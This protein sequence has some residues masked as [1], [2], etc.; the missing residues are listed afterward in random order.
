M[1][2]L[3]AEIGINHN[4]SVE[5]ALEMTRAFSFVDIIKMQKFD[6]KSMTKEKYNSEHPNPANAF[7]ETYGKHKE[8]LEL[9]MKDY[10]RV[11]NLAESQGQ[12]FA[13]SFFDIESAKKVMSIKPEYIKIPSPRANNFKLIS[14][15][16]RTWDGPIH[17]STGMTTLSERNKIERLSKNFI[18]Y[19][20]TSNYSEGGEI[21]I[22][23]KYPGFSCHSPN[24]LFA[25][26]AIMNGARWIEFHVTLDRRSKGTDHCISLLPKEYLQLKKW[27]DKNR[28]SIDRIHHKKPDH[29]PDI[30]KAARKKLW[31][32]V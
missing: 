23:Q 11:K 28:K 27:I 29:L 10:R 32:T 13:A 14:Y 20:C 5:N 16:L 9:D 24:I 4:G 2:K 8:Y 12:K 31:S 25:Q 22:E 17:I 1:V 18:I 6:P 15:C 30:E 19:S 7:G 26:A 21:Y 3:I